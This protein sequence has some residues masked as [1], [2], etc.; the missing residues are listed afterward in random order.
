MDKSTIN[1]D[2]VY[3]TETGCQAP[4]EHVPATVQYSGKKKTATLN[5]MDRLEANTQYN[6]VVEGAND[7]DPTVKSKVGIAMSDTFTW[8]FTTGSS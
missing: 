4:C 5:P 2:T 7:G 6:A 8:T 1:T 3:L